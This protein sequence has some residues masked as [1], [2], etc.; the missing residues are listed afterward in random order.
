MSILPQQ[1]LPAKSFFSFSEVTAYYKA[2]DTFTLG[3]LQQNCGEAPFQL[4]KTKWHSPSGEKNVSNHL[5][6][7]Q[8][9]ENKVV[10]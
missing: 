5:F 2:P 6:Q 1:L 10:K 7:G 3:F 9:T 4:L 8:V